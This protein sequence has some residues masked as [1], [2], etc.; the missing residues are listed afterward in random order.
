M[1]E[2]SEC[3]MYE[4]VCKDEFRQLNEK[5]DSL[6]KN[7]FVNGSINEIKS[8]LKENTNFRKGGIWLFG[9]LIFALIGQLAPPIIKA[10]AGLIK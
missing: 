6:T 10:I 3:K 7:L 1:G 2:A 8:E 4:L 9:V 5:L